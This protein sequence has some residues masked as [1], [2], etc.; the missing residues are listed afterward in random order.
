M[1]FA[2]SSDLRQFWFKI[3]V[4]VSDSYVFDDVDW[5]QDVGPVER[6][7]DDNLIFTSFSA[8]SHLTK[9]FNHFL[10]IQTDSKKLVCIFQRNIHCLLFNVWRDF[11]LSII[12]N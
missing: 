7:I 6:N 1:R 5:M 10:L 9:Q 3:I 4:T 11:L 2:Y 12:R 8:V